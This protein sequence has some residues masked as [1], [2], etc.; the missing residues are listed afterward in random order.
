MKKSVS[1]IF[2][3]LMVAALFLFT[4]VSYAKDDFPSKQIKVVVPYSAGGASDREV[5]MIQPFIEKELG[6]PLQIE[7]RGGAGTEIANTLV[8]RAAGDGYTVL[9]TNWASL[10][11]NT[12]LKKPV[13]KFKDFTPLVVAVID[14]RIMIV[15]E[16]SPFKNLMDVIEAVNKKP[17][18]IAFGCATGGAQHLSLLAL[19]KELNLDFKIVGYKGGSKARAAMLG[20][21]VDGAMGEVAGAYYLRKQTRALA[22][23]HDKVNPLWPEGKPVNEQLEQ[24]GIKTKIPYFAR[25]G[26]FMVKTELKEK[27]PSRYEKLKNALLKAS[28]SEKYLEIAKKT[29]Y[30]DILDWNDAA[31]FTDSFDYQYKWIMKTKSFWK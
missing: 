2:V 31:K 1:S 9:Y 26:I 12:I 28:K 10:T 29:G 21:H 7:N 23:F 22:I 25:C 13:Y 5:R 11:M 14:P 3:V 19:K 16:D 6:V 8:Y 15:K 18:K 20:G 27:Y 24:A 17:G 30:G 4:A